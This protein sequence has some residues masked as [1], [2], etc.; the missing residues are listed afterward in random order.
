MVSFV[1]QAMLVSLLALA[2]PHA[3]RAAD[4]LTVGDGRPSSCTEMAV[5]HALTMAE[6]RGGG[7]VR[8]NCGR[9]PV[10]IALNQTVDLDG[11]PALLVVPDNTTVDGGGLITLDG[12]DAGTVILVRHGTTVT[13]KNLKIVNGRD[14]D[15]LAGGIVNFGTLALRQVTLSSSSGFLSG[16]VWNEGALTLDGSTVTGNDSFLL[17]GGLTNR[18]QL[19]VMKSFVTGNSTAFSGGGINNGGQLTIQQSTVSDNFAGEASGGGIVNGGTLTVRQ[20]TFARN[21]GF[22]GGGI[23]NLGTASVT[24]SLFSGNAANFGAGMYDNSTTQQPTAVSHTAFSGNNAFYGGGVFVESGAFGLDHSVLLG[25][26]ALVFGGGVFAAGLVTAEQ[27]TITRNTSG[28][29][30][31]VY[32][33]TAGLTPSIAHP[34]VGALGL[35]HSI[36]IGNTPNDI[37][38]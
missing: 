14:N 5:E 22:F 21:L 31:G 11:V 4:P 15:G 2:L 25:N 32:V 28:L 38:P 10:T 34:C 29:G 27:T 3:A 36:V 37:T 20:S 30:G 1:A 26:S 19:A 6:V 23:A 13:L 17:G 7:T 24:H 9:A 18:G 8:F 35:R 12:T 16:G 33:C